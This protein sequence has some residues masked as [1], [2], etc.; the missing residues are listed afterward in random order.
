M[1]SELALGTEVFRTD[2]Y[3]DAAFADVCLAQFRAAVF[4]DF[5]VRDLRMGG[6]HVYV[7]A[8]EERLHPKGK[9]L[10]KKLKSQKRLISHVPFRAQFLPLRGRA[11]RPIPGKLFLVGDPKQSIY[12]FRRADV[13]L[14]EEV[15]E[16]LL[17]VGAELLHLT[18]SFRSPPSIQ[19]FVN[20]AFAPAMAVRPDTSQAAYVPLQPSRREIGGQRTIVALPVPRPYGD[21][22]KIVDWC[23]DW[24]WFQG[25]QG[26]QA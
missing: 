20:G 15:K 24:R 1:L 11:V 10:L 21:Y 23:C 2:E 26:R 16:R 4:E 19:S 9:E 7:F 17:S 5:V 18:T 22:G 6:W 12:R 8:Q 25:P 14:Y 13:A 3:G